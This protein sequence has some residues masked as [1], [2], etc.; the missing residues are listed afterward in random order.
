MLFVKV[1]TPF[2]VNGPSTIVVLM[3]LPIVVVALP[4]VFTLVAPVTLVA[5]SV[6]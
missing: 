5:A 4:L 2:A 6:D 3:A 1:E